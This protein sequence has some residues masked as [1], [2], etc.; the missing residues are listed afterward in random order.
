MF[1]KEFDLKIIEEKKNNIL[2]TDVLGWDLDYD[3]EKGEV[4]SSIESCVD[5][6]IVNYLD[7][8]KW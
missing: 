7:S 1:E 2:S 5:R 8:K 6:I 4:T 3:L